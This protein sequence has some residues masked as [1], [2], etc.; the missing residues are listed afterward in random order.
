VE[1]SNLREIE[2]ARRRLIDAIESSSEGFAFY[3]SQDRLVICNTRYRELL[4]PGSDLP[5]EPGMEFASII[6]RA[7]ESGLITDA[8]GRIEEWVA[9]RM[10]I[11]RDP[12]KPRLQQRRDG[13]WILISERQT[14]DRGTVAV[15]SDITDLKQR[16]EELTTKSNA[17][18][19]LSNQLAK[20][21]SPQVYD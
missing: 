4:Y 13:R 17:L 5:F 12:G 3:D 15:Y 8:V 18:E 16:E 14:G 21:L 1:K 7:A 20:Y 2:T 11:H 19:Q 6:R 9:E 10:A